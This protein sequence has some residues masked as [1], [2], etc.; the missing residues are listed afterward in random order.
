MHPAGIKFGLSHGLLEL[1]GAGVILSAPLL[2]G[3][4]KLYGGRVPAI[5]S[6][7]Q[8][9]YRDIYDHLYRLDQSL[10][11]LRDTVSTAVSVNLS[12]ITLAENA[13]TKQLA[14]YAALV[15]P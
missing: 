14:S 9:Y 2:E 11:G 8:E 4:S 13:T 15:A 10:D 3:I 12:L 1:N 5:C 6:G 7:T